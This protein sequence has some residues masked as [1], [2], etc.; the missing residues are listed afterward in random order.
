MKKLISLF[1]ALLVAAG[2]LTVSSCATSHDDLTPASIP[3]Y[4]VGGFANSTGISVTPTPN[5]KNNFYP[6]SFADGVATFKFTQGSDGW[7]DGFPEDSMHFQITEFAAWDSGWNVS[8]G[9]LE[10]NADYVELSAGKP[11]NIEVTGLTKGKTYTISVKQDG[12]K[13]SAKIEGEAAKTETTETEVDVSVLNSTTAKQAGAYI[14]IE[15]CSLKSAESTILAFGGKETATNYIVVKSGDTNNWSGSNFQMWAKF[16]VGNKNK[17]I[18]F[19]ETTLGNT[20]KIDM[21]KD[22]SKNHNNLVVTDLKIPDTAG[23]VYKI[24]VSTTA[25]GATVVVSKVE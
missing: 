2:T 7:A 20:S 18:Y 13:V 14:K 10:L 6:I 16:Y 19:D 5:G 11:S 24:T 22:E 25:D 4:I 9:T 12:S 21:T 3:G 17:Q 15:G 23:G 1:A 8:S